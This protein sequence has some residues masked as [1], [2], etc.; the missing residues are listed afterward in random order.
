M[1]IIAP[2]DSG[3]NIE[4]TIAS[5]VVGAEQSLQP[6]QPKWSESNFGS[7]ESEQIE[8]P[9]QRCENHPKKRDK[10]DRERSALSSLCYFIHLDLL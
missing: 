9:Q 5:K 8:S 10:Y 3:S 7:G 1:R 4:A 6:R 2:R